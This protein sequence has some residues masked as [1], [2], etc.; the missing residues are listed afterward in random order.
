MCFHKLA[1]IQSWLAI[2]VCFKQYR[3]CAHFQAWSSKERVSTICLRLRNIQVS[4]LISFTEFSCTMKTNQRKTLQDLCRAV[5]KVLSFQGKLFIRLLKINSLQFNLC[6]FFMYFYIPLLTH[7][8]TSLGH[9]FNFQ[10]YRWG[11]RSDGLFRQS[12]FSQ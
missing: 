3:N 12:A 7:T 4:T 9:F 6:L 2:L 5:I 10:T 11:R 1:G 8:L